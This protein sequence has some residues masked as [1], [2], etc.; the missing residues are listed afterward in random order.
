M[1]VGDIHEQP[2]VG[3]SAAFIY[4]SN[5]RRQYRFNIVRDFPNAACL[6]PRNNTDTATTPLTSAQGSKSKRTRP[7]RVPLARVGRTAAGITSASCETCTLKCPP[8][9]GFRIFH[10]TT[11]KAAPPHLDHALHAD[12]ASPG[13]SDLFPCRVHLRVQA[14]AR[15]NRA[16]LVWL[17]IRTRFRRRP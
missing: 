15:R 9:P 1:G 7:N 13:F 14:G 10:P 11:P 4:N 12:T 2:L 16:P 3:S 17:Y 8:T 6:F 5:F